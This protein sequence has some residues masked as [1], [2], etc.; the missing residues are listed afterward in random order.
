MWRLTF[1]SLEDGTLWEMTVDP[2]YRNFR[3]SGW[4]HVV[5]H[6]SP[7]G[8][9]QNL[10]RTA[11]RTQDGTGVLT[12]DSPADL[13]WRSAD[14]G[15]ALDLVTVRDRELNPTDYERLFDE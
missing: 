10:R 5:E 9:Y 11:R 14:L 13:V 3:R 8:A 6:E 1:Y 4:E 2:S 7:W 12:A 15:Q